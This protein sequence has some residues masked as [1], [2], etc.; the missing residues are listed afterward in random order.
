MKNLL[1][2]LALSSYL[3]GEPQN[4]KP[5][6]V[7]PGVIHAPLEQRRQ[8]VIDQTQERKAEYFSRDYE[9]ILSAKSIGQKE[10]SQLANLFFY[11]TGTMGGYFDEPR[12]EKVRWVLGFHPEIGPK[13]GYP[14]FVDAETGLT[15]QEGQTEKVDAL[16]LIKFFVANRKPSK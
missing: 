15:W 6:L 11:S 10:A 7:N 5:I 14:V 8:W 12:K 16:S 2:F 9:W 1:S 3:L 13:D 4:P